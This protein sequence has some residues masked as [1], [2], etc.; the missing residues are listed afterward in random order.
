MTALHPMVCYHLWIFGKNEI[1]VKYETPSTVFDERV[2]SAFTTHHAM[3]E[4]VC[5]ILRGMCGSLCLI[6]GNCD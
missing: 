3:A 1:N 6:R 4:S 5:N 2:I